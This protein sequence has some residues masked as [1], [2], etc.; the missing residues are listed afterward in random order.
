MNA[1]GKFIDNFP[2][3]GPDRRFEGRR[4]FRL[5]DKPFPAWDDAAGAATRR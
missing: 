3:V 1:L 5:R 2:E 4:I